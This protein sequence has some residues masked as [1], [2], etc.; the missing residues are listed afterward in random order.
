MYMFIYN[1]TFIVLYGDFAALNISRNFVV[2]FFPTKS[3][4]DCV[5]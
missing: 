5:L 2:M 3:L 1:N 4:I